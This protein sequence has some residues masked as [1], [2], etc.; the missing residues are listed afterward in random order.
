MDRLASSREVED[1]YRSADIFV[2]PSLRDSGGL[3]VL[4]AMAHGLPVVCADLGGPGL[5]VDETC[6]RAVSAKGKNKRQLASEF[7]APCEK[8]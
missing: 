1:R 3:V 2:F 4:E 6:G 7:A 5:I 8:S